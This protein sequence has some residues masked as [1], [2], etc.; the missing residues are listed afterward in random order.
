MSI[1]TAMICELF[2]ENASPL[3]TNSSV[4]YSIAWPSFSRAFPACG[5]ICRLGLRVNCPD[6]AGSVIAGAEKL[7]VERVAIPTIL[8]CFFGGA[9]VFIRLL[10]YRFRLANKNRAVS[11][12]ELK[13]SESHRIADSGLLAILD[14]A[15]LN[16]TGRSAAGDPSIGTRQDFDKHFSYRRCGQINVQASPIAYLARQFLLFARFP[17]HLLDFTC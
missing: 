16:F 10:M 7:V 2:D 15:F 8:T 14:S 6:T 1:W 9:R 11:F 12:W 13:Q 5:V 3:S 4:R 17:C